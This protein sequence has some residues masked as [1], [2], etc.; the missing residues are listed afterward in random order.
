VPLSAAKLEDSKLL[1]AFVQALAADYPQFITA[2][3]VERTRPDESNALSPHAEGQRTV[4]PYYTRA[5][6]RERRWPAPD[7]GRMV[8]RA[9]VQINTT[10]GTWR[11]R[12][13]VLR[14]RSV[15]RD[16]RVEQAA[17]AGVIRTSFVNAEGGGRS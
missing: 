9:A 10:S 7:W 14:A 12:S 17:E 5:P 8:S 1:A 6:G 2:K 15:G 11:K 13:A 16:V 3:I 4:A